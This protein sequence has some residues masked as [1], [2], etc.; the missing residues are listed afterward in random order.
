[1]MRKKKSKSRKPDAWASPPKPY[2]AIVAGEPS[3]DSLGAGLISA[4]IKRYPDA[5]FLGVGG[6][7][8]QSKGLVP[9]YPIDRLSMNGFFEPILHLFRL[10]FLVVRLERFF[11][12]H[13]PQ[14]FIGIDFNVFNLMLERRLRKKGVKVVHYVS[15][16]VYAWRSWRA[17]RVASSADMLLTLFPFESAFY[18]DLDLKVKYVG[19]PLADAIL[20]DTDKKKNRRIKTSGFGISLEQPCVAMLPG[21]RSGE[22]KRM[23][24]IFLSSARKIASVYGD[25]VFLIP[26][27]SKDIKRLADSMVKTFS[28][29]NVISYIGDSKMALQACDVALTKAG[30][31][32]LETL[33][34]ERPMVVAYRLDLL[35]YWIIKL[36]LTTP[37]VALPN[38]LFGK[39]LVDEYIQNKATPKILSDRIIRLL[40]RQ[41]DHSHYLRTA[42]AIHM[43]LAQNANER[44]AEAVLS[45]LG[46]S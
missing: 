45:L 29:L 36:L 2:I 44:A 7:Q 9:L 26:C 8:M 43:E 25:V 12:R 3:G 38:I 40:D 32:T 17:K 33:L 30:T 46:E 28:D 41:Y 19:H 11:L 6:N 20:L 1:M 10:V 35:S 21:S 37:Y 4:L 16:S 22:F 31:S 14:V 24:P 23:A 39:P 42:R 5:D 15:P 13:R 34:L 27:I 18:S